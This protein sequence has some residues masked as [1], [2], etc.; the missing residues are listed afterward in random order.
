MIVE[1]QVVLSFT[2]SFLLLLSLSAL[3][4]DKNTSR[5]FLSFFFCF[6]NRGEFKKEHE[7]VEMLLH[8][9]YSMYAS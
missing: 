8:T 6:L 7:L 9:A 1:A 4:E 2:S 5:F 3:L